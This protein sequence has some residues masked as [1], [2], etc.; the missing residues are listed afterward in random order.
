MGP[1]LAT[2]GTLKDA[3]PFQLKYE[4]Y[5]PDIKEAIPLGR[6][7]SHPPH[8]RAFSTVVAVVDQSKIPIGFHISIRLH[9][10]FNIKLFTLRPAKLFCEARP[11]HKTSNA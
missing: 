9:V 8:S 11:D 4:G 3:R 1:Y 5:V 2:I 10:F 7:R 6:P